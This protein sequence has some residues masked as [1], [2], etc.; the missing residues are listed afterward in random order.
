MQANNR[1]P[2]EAKMQADYDAIAKA[3]SLSRQ[4]L[5]WPEVA[6]EIDVLAAGA[7]M[8]DVGCG[9]GR[10]YETAKARGLQYSGIDISEGQITEG[11]RL[12]PD[13]DLQ[14]GSMLALPYAD[15]SFDAVFI[16]AALHHLLTPKEREQAIAEAYRV[17]KP[18]GKVVVT[19]MAL[20]QPKYWRLFW[21]PNHTDMQPLSWRDVCVEWSWKVQK[22]VYRYYHAF[23]RGELLGLFTSKQWQV[24]EARYVRQGETE[25]AYKAKNLVLTARKI[26]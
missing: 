4:D 19:V 6:R 25:K 16:V 18:G 7:T 9:M 5:H 24:E 11:K 1:T 20:W 12:H 22:P 2:I 26:V 23:R 3:F 17:L 14:V 8:L 13:A 15:A 10:L 21:Q